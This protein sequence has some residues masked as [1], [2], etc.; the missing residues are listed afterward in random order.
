[1]LN[2]FEAQSSFYM[3]QRLKFGKKFFFYLRG[4]SK[5]LLSLKV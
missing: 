2:L 3:Y 4:L 5:V 1:M